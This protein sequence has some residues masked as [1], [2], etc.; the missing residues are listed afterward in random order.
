MAANERTTQQLESGL[1]RH[2][3]VCVL[4]HNVDEEFRVLGPFISEGFRKGDKAFHIID[5]QH[6]RDHLRRLHDDLGIDVSAS[7]QSGQ[8]EVRAGRRFPRRPAAS[9]STPCWRWLRPS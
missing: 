9:T 2:R 6:R 5:R 8:L 1:D 4:Y 7:E 3:H